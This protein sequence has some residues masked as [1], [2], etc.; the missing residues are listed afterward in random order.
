MQGWP[1]SKAVS[2]KKRAGTELESHT[3][4]PWKRPRCG[5]PDSPSI[6]E[7]ELKLQRNRLRRE[8]RKRFTVFGGR[9]EKTDLTYK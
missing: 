2:L 6:T 3:S 1:R 8:R 9:W 5:V 7:S 4:D